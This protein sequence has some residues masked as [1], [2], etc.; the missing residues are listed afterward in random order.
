MTAVAA[1]AQATTVLVTWNLWQARDVPPTLPLVS[2]L[3]GVPWGPFLLVL[4]AAT[5]V[6]PRVAGV[7]FCVAYVLAVLGDQTRL[8]PEL[9]SLAVLMTAPSF[10]PA[11]VSL[12][13]WHLTTLW[14]WAGLHKV[15]SLGWAGGS[16]LAIAEY[17][18]APGARLVVAF[19]VPTLEIGLGV[20][21]GFRRA[22]PVV[23]WLAVALHVGILLTLSPV[24]GDWNSAVWAWN[25]G[26]AVVGFALFSPTTDE[27]YASRTWAAAGVLAL[28]P[29]LFYVGVTDAYLAHH[30]YSGN[31]ASAVVCDAR[32]VCGRAEF[33]TSDLNVPLPPE[34]RLYR[35]WF[36]ERCEPGASIVIS[37]PHTRLS[38][39]PTTYRRHT[40]PGR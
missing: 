11:G 20:A 25:A 3:A 14:L 31:A 5:V 38:D 13:R 18:D 16:A 34:P 28:Y 15:L 1:T 26:L 9:V 30:L 32:G 19:V 33:D 8:Q 12:A 2:S 21:S 36:D 22:W 29:A 6:V 35:Q 40:G 7:A 27:A 10:G 17:M 39:P 23:R 4:A 24:F 37:G